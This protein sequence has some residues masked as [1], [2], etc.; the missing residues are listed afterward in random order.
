MA[1]AAVSSSAAFGEVG[2]YD[3]VC[4]VRSLGASPTVRLRVSGNETVL[5]ASPKGCLERV[6]D[7]TDRLLPCEVSP[8]RTAFAFSEGQRCT[9]VERGN[10]IELGRDGLVK[11]YRRVWHFEC[12][13]EPLFPPATARAVYGYAARGEWM[14][15]LGPLERVT[16]EELE[17]ILDFLIDRV[18]EIFHRVFFPDEGPKSLMAGS[19]LVKRASSGLPWSL[20][21]RR[22]GS[23]LRCYIVLNQLARAPFVGKGSSC[24]AWRCLSLYPGDAPLCF[25]SGAKESMDPAFAAMTLLFRAPSTENLSIPWGCFAYQSHKRREQRMGVLLDLY[26][27]T[28]RQ[29]QGSTSWP[30]AGRMT[31]VDQLL[32]AVE[33]MHAVGVV[34]RDLKRDNILVDP[35]SRRLAIGDWNSALTPES[36]MAVRQVRRTT[37]EA[38]PPELRG[39]LMRHYEAHCATAPEGHVSVVGV[40]DLEVFG[41]AGDMWGVANI[42]AELLTTKSLCR[43]PAREAFVYGGRR[44]YRYLRDELG[45]FV[46]PTAAESDAKVAARLEEIGVPADWKP[47]LTELYRID[48]T[49]RATATRARELLGQ[50]R[51][52][53]AMRILS[54]LPSLGWSSTRSSAPLPDDAAAAGA[55]ARGGFRFAAGTFS[56]ASPTALRS[57]RKRDREVFV[58]SAIDEPS[59]RTRNA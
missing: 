21:V 18:E 33:A 45:R 16:A 8:D 49:R 53:D 48:P 43:S 42:I 46:A 19:I 4:L 52:A 56:L 55:A 35:A 7:L 28:L 57:V 44:E 36:S 41:P 47:L 2:K 5:T 3:L 51:A 13:V 23:E 27:G 20:V 59:K 26:P 54:I 14:A 15:A 17:R 24:T 22:V 38:T 32:R 29:M 34:H 50:V 25:L 11:Q 58:H 6:A 39:A 12:P 10:K 40:R 31:L 9:L 1:A 30:I 37:L